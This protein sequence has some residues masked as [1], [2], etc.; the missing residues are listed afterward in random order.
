MPDKDDLKLDSPV[1]KLDGVGPKTAEKLAKIGVNV[2]SDLLF[3]LPTRYQNKTKITP[4]NY[5]K[6]GE[7]SLIEG[8]L[9]TKQIV[10]RGRRS[11]V[12]RVTDPSGSV[13]LRFFHF[14]KS[15]TDKLEV[16]SKIQC[17]GLTRKTV[18]G[19]ELIHP[20]YKLA[21]IFD[22]IP[23]NETL[24]AI[25]PLT[26][27]IQQKK[28]SSLI[29]QTINILEKS[30]PSDYEL[31]PETIRQNF[32]LADIGESIK[33][34][35]Y[36]SAD[37]T[38]PIRKLIYPYLRRLAFEELLAQKLYLT[39][40]RNQNMKRIA[41]SVSCSFL[42]DKFLNGLEFELTGNQQKVISE[43]DADLNRNIPMNRLLQGDVGS[44]KTVVA[45][46]ICTNILASNYKVA[47]M[48]PTEILAEQH[49]KTL[50]E[51]FKPLGFETI[52]VT[53]KLSAFERKDIVLHIAS[54]K[55]LIVVGTHALFQENL[56]YRKLGLAIIDE[57]HR[58]GVEQREALLRKSRSGKFR[59]HQLVMTATPIPRTLAMTAY[60]HLDISLLKS[61][62]KGRKTVSTHL[63]PESRRVEIIERIRIAFRGGRQIY[64]VCPLIEKSDKLE[65]KAA[66]LIAAEL[67]RE[68]PGLG[69][70]LIHGRLSEQEKYDVMQDFILG[71]T[72]LLVATT[73][74]EVGV[75]A[76]N[77]TLI[78]IEN[79]EHLGLSQLHQLRG[80]VGRSQLKANC[81]LLYK[82]PLS[83]MART[84]LEIIRNTN[85]GFKIAELD[86]ELRGPGEFL[87]K[88]QSGAFQFKIADLVRDSRIVAE[89]GNAAIEMKSID[90]NT[91]DRL[92][93]RWAI[94]KR[95]SAD[96]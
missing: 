33:N 64:W 93:N 15:Q 24:T 87:G 37:S 48:A 79:S 47:L 43:I 95:L 73:V 6:N 34:I 60:S 23:I 13:T 94:G 76:P 91:I 36:P 74:I 88:R 85:D 41:P 61:L 20:E 32:K 62:P 11:L 53:G 77:A 51:W 38:D 42:R 67:T 35:H 86:L 59:A 7:E 70:S 57:Q 19:F 68:L 92:C 22:K 65:K 25:Y 49:H 71:N 28:M 56:I 17:F 83:E 31:L 75:D 81:I 52:L 96:I 14:S 89:I 2:A 80:R 18:R 12:C 39:R 82:N 46:A 4:I 84:R 78:V 26:E 90:D 63:I 54:E 40:G 16:G 69:V 30:N 50:M 58:F 10:Y 5:L 66:T 1:L 27:G 21:N 29:R 44:G 8:V 55:P 72:S 3:H 45:G 9:E